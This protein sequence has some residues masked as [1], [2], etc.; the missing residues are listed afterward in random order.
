MGQNIIFK[1]KSLCYSKWFFSVF[2][3]IG[4]GCRQGDPISPYLFILCAEIMSI[5]IR[6]NIN[7]KGIVIKGKEY[8]LLQYAYDTV[9][10][11]DG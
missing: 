7:I 9:L 2:F 10:L 4:R 11:L 8:K 3:E 1:S 6:N 5:L